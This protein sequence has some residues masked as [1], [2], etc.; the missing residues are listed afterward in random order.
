MELKQYTRSNQS[1]KM[2][3]PKAT[4]ARRYSNKAPTNFKGGPIEAP[5][6]G[7]DY[8]YGFALIPACKRDKDT[9]FNEYQL[10]P[11]GWMLPGG[12][13]TCNNAQVMKAAIEIDRLI[14]LCGGLPAG[15][16]SDK[17]VN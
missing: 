11:M 9:D 10:N 14:K 12:V 5:R 17:S 2:A 16:N 1:Y 8:A 13:W 3:A 4:D 6:S 15:F 7:E